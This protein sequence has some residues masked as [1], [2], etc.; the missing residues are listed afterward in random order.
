MFPLHPFPSFSF[1]FFSSPS[2][3]SRH[4]PVALSRF[5]TLLSRARSTTFPRFSRF[6]FPRPRGFDSLSFHLFTGFLQSP[7]R[8]TPSLRFFLPSLRRCVRDNC[9]PS[10]PR[11]MARDRDEAKPKRRR[12]ILLYRGN[13]DGGINGS[14]FPLQ[15]Y[16]LRTEDERLRGGGNIPHLY[17]LSQLS[18]VSCI[19]VT[20]IRDFGNS[21]RIRS[22]SNIR[23]S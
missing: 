11:R 8:P 1:L 14:R 7:P 21:I 10:Y 12:A 18:V 23:R 16:R 17:R 22:I 6:V 15:T 9:A 2:I 13:E 19:V 4:T 5:L 20:V 3:L